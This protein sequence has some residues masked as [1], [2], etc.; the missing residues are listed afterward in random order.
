MRDG[1]RV[2][3]VRNDLLG[4]EGVV[5]DAGNT[6]CSIRW[7]TGP[8]TGAVDLVAHRHLVPTEGSRSISDEVDFS[9]DDGLVSFPAHQVMATRGVSGVYEAMVTEGH[10]DHLDSVAEEALELVASR[11][12]RDPSF[13]QV[14]SAV[15]DDQ[16]DH[17]V[18]YATSRFLREALANADLEA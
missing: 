7:E 14:I 12:R 2:S 9:L 15:G 17:L 6:G 16:G 18:A 11:L 13:R 5:L 10:L 8:R 1:Q 4:S 3:C